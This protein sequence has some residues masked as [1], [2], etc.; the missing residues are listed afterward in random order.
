MSVR[1]AQENFP[2][3]RAPRGEVGCLD[4]QPP[5]PIGSWAGLHR[6]NQKCEGWE[7]VWGGGEWEEKGWGG[8]KQALPP[9]ILTKSR[10]SHSLA[11]HLVF[12]PPASSGGKRDHACPQ[13]AGC[14][15]HRCLGN[16]AIRSRCSPLPRLPPS[17]WLQ[18]LRS[19]LPSPGN[20]G[21]TIGKTRERERTLRCCPSE[22][23]CFRSQLLHSPPWG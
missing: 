19:L 18:P 17:L 13:C 6:A 1:R 7:R 5:A 14:Q 11:S 15:W 8:G 21:M 12:S 3:D 4:F 20:S 9:P 16:L 23:S 2:T 10:P 22:F